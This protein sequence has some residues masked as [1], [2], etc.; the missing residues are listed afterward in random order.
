MITIEGLSFSYGG[1]E[2]FSRL[3]LS[4]AG[5]GSAGCWERTGLVKPPC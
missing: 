1:E 3:D 5:G 4:L 2:L